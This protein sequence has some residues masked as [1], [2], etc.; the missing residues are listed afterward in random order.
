MEI[1]RSRAFFRP[2]TVPPVMVHGST[3]QLPSMAAPLTGPARILVVDDDE[4]SLELLGTILAPLGE[5]VVAARSGVEALGLAREQEFAVILLDVAMPVMDGFETARLMKEADELRHVPIIFLTGVAER[6]EVARGYSAGAVDYLLKPYEPEI[7]RSK[8]EVFVDLYRLRRQAE[9]LTHRAL[10]DGLTGLPNRTLLLDRLEVALA[11][12]DRTGKDVAILF[13]DLDSFKRVN[14]TLGHQAGDQVLVDTAA[15]LQQAIRAS[16]T[17][18][19]FGGDEFV[20]LCDGVTDRAEAE[21]IAA[22]IAQTLE[23]GAGGAVRASIGIALAERPDTAPEELL[24][25]ADAA[26]L[27]AKGSAPR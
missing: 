19:R 16:D 1:P 4:G 22:R 15:C 20:V 3:T 25:E 21:A 5:T 8:V 13:V 18:S 10:H 24:R 12:I 6:S 17:A 9:V 26:M 14:D 2:P 7:L 11:R 27:A 23:R